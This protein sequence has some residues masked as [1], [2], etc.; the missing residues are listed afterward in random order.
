MVKLLLLKV[1]IT[2]IVVW[3]KEDFIK[4]A[5]KQLGVNDIYEEGPHD[6]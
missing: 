5:G 3:N 6:S 2:A 1:L 4:K